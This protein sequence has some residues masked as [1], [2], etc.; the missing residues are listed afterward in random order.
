VKL[1]AGRAHG[2]LERR[3]DFMLQVTCEGYLEEEAL[4]PW[5]PSVCFLLRSSAEWVRLAHMME[6]HLFYPK[7]AHFYVD[8]V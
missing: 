8:H 1:W 5:R 4:L 6:G 3:E 2:R 7:C